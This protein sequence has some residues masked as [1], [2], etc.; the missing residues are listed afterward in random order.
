[1]HLALAALAVVTNAVGAGVEFRA[2]RRQR[3]LM[4]EVLAVVNRLFGSPGAAGRHEA[5]QGRGDVAG[6]RLA[7]TIP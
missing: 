3:M 1:V 5:D 4:D 6:Q 7:E 2:I